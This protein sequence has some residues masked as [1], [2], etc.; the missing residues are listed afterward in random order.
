LRSITVHLPEAYLAALDEIVR[1]DHFPNRAEAIRTAV[2]DLIKEE[3]FLFDLNLTKKI[4][5]LKEKL[6]ELK[7]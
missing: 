2:R 4:P 5:S 7:N 6:E 1:Q 3:D